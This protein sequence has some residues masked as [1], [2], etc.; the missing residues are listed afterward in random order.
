MICPC[1]GKSREISSSDCAS[2]GAKQVGPPLAPPD[3]LMP[4]LGP[5]FAALA[6]G[7]VVIIAFL[8]TWIFIRDAKV[9]RALAVWTLGDGLE[10]TQSLIKGDKNLPYYRIFAFDAYRLA[11][12]FSLGAIP[13]S[14]A[15]IWLARRATRL[16]KSDSAGFGGMRMARA[17]YFLS[18]GLLIVFS[19]VTISSI[20]REIAKMKA[21]HAAA[22]RALMYELHAQAL[23]RYYKEYGGY[24]RELDKDYLSRV[25]AEETPRS[26]YWGGSF[27]YKPVAVVASKG[28]A[29]PYSDYALRSAGPDGKLGTEDDIVMVNGVIV[30]T[31]NEPDSPNSM[32]A[33]QKR[34][35][36]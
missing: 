11:F 32:G 12:Y 16:I 18:I 22:T 5:S 25:N 24:P 19:A 1:C 17:S 36:Q 6:C 31:Q 20:P 29:A 8:L 13:L 21:Q 4:K 26:D 14:L 28:A 34:A 2:C 10:L 35:R 30:D 9:A 23:Q 15:G 3:V 7:V 33:I 27:D